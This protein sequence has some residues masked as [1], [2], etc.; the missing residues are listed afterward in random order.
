MPHH[1]RMTKEDNEDFAKCWN[2]EMSFE[3]MQTRFGKNTV[4]AVKHHA[5]HLRRKGFQMMDR[6]EVESIEL[7][8]K[9]DYYENGKPTARHPWKT[10]IASKVKF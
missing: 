8:L 2:E 6:R 4:S 7:K 9:T 10:S 5:S 1:Y 3:R